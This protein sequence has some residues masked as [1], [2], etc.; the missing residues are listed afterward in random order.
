MQRSLAG[1]VSTF[2]VLF[3]GEIVLRRT[4]N[5]HLAQFA[6]NHIGKK[7]AFWKQVTIFIKLAL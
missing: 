7:I 6:S 2:T 1:A 3:A 5:S 4:Q